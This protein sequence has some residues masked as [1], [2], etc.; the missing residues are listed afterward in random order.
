MADM[1]TFVQN[2]T[3]TNLG[4]VDDA[5]HGDNTAVAFGLVTMAGLSTCLGAAVVFV[6]RLAKFATPKFLA[7]GVAFSAG[8][9][10]Y[11]SFVEIFQKAVL[12]FQDAG[13]EA[14]FAY[15]FASTSFFAG[16]AFML[17]SS[18]FYMVACYCLQAL[19][20]THTIPSSPFASSS[21]RRF[22]SSPTMHIPRKTWHRPRIPILP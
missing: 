15:T 17:V 12:S 8:V 7:G 14:K 4:D 9:M 19:C 3:T 21:T 10:L 2:T 13:H 5:G 20:Q 22:I 11:V 6:P 16:I 1:E 18:N